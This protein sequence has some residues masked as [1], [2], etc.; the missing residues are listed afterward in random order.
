M[1]RPRSD[2]SNCVTIDERK[3]SN[4]SGSPRTGYFLHLGLNVDD[5]LGNPEYVDLEK[6]G[7]DATLIKRGITYKVSRSQGNRPHIHINQADFDRF[8]LE[9]G[10]FYTFRL[11]EGIM[12]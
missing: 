10:Q 11:L 1:A 7:L 9:I 3:G 4:L 2:A 12:F 8:N 6:F 5:N